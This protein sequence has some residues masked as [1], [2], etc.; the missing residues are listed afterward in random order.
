MSILFKNIFQYMFITF[1]SASACFFTASHTKKKN[2]CPDVSRAL[3]FDSIIRF[4][5]QTLKINLF[6]GVTFLQY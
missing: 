1:S 4:C 2:S 5:L 6:G 3:I